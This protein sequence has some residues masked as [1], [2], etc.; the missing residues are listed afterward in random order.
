[1]GEGGRGLE[2][3]GT[4]GFLSRRRFL[5][6]SAVSWLGAHCRP[7]LGGPLDESLLDVTQAIGWDVQAAGSFY[8]LQATDLHASEI[9]QG[10]LKMPD[11]YGGKNFADDMNRLAPAPAFLAIT[12]DLIAMTTRSPS[13]WPQAEAGFQRVNGKIVSRLTMPCHM[14]IGNNDCSPEAFHKVWP[15]RPVHWSFDLQGVHFVGLHGYNTWKPEN[16]NHAGILLDGA[17]LA[18]LARDVASAAKA[19]TLVLFT[20]ETL[21]DPDC[22]RIRKQLAP[23]LATFAGEVW[24]IAGHNHA[25]AAH[26]VLIGEKR[27]HVLETL[28]PVGSWVP[29]KGA[30][31][32][33]FVSGGRVVGSALRWLTKDG[34]PIRFEVDRLIRKDPL[35]P[36]P[37]DLLRKGEVRTYMVGEEDVPLRYDVSSVTDRVS[38]LYLA[39]GQSF[40]YRVP[41]EDWGRTVGRLALAVKTQTEFAVAFSADGRNWLPDENV[42]A[43][44][45]LAVCEIPRRLLSGRQLWLRVAVPEKKTLQVYGVSFLT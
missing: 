31:R 23:L 19:Q 35:S 43:T 10:A 12:G 6:G 9:T 32:L 21:C 7:A 42:C 8:F 4:S 20:H 25:N 39:G 27:V 37:E 15:E 30:Y 41:L 2:S 24:N 22:H 29:D 38:N 18:W 5:A 34:D 14:I 3:Q 26:T 28:S 45:G 44:A 17:Q 13:T 16:S 33:V 36:M 1:M 11:K 40:V